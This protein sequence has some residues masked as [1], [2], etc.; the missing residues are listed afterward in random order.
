M[1]NIVFIPLLALLFT[2]FAA[3]AQSN[4]DAYAL[5]SQSGCLACHKPD[6]KLIGPSY[7][8]VATKYHDQSDASEYLSNK[9]KKG[10]A[11]VWGRIP[12]PAHPQLSDESIK[13]LVAWILRGAPSQ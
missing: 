9:I 11:G 5:A 2:V 6:Q 1:K 8:S 3:S 7:E 4:Q 10:G 12:M 13:T